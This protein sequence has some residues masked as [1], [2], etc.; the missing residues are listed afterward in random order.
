[1]NSIQKEVIGHL[2]CRRVMECTNVTEADISMIHTCDC[3]YAGQTEKRY[4]LQRMNQRS[5]QIR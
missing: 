2:L 4:I 3:S 1:M 5:S